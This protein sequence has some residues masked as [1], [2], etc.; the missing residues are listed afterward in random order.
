MSEK[1][2]NAKNTS[3]VKVA[4][5]KVGV[6][7]KNTT[8]KS[9]IKKIFVLDTNVILH[10]SSCIFKF[11]EHDICIPIQV[12]EELDNHKKGLDTINFHAR[13][14]NRIFDEILPR[15]C[16]DKWVSLGKGLGKIKVLLKRDFHEEVSKNL[17]MNK[18]DNQIIN[19]A[20]DL[21]ETMKI[22]DPKVKVVIVS[23][24]I[25]VRSKSKILNIFCEDYLNEK[26]SN[27]D[28]LFREVRTIKQK[29]DFSLKLFSDKEMEFKIEGALEN[30]NFI[31]K[32]AT[33]DVLVRYRDGKIKP[34]TKKSNSN[35]F[36]LNYLNVEQACAIDALLDPEIKLVALEGCPGTGKTLVSL[37]CAL[38]QLD[39]TE[40][41]RV[42]FA[43]ATV[44]MGN[45][46]IGFL[47]GDVQ[48]KISPYAKGVSDNV[49]FLSISS[50]KN[51]KKIE[52]FSKD[53]LF[54]IEALAHL[55]GRSL[56]NVLF[57][58]DEAQ[59]LT[60]LE[61]RTIITRAG[62]GTKIIIMA[63][64]RQIDNPYVDQ[65]SNGFTYAVNQF[66]AK[67]NPMFSYVHLNKSERSELA[68]LASEIL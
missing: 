6:S 45:R 32:F 13:E 57:I 22:K 39:K 51:K 61:I 18:Y 58:V 55:R 12:L 65:K 14:F 7:S 19:A 3:P 59:N 67:N 9:K 16:S 37:A 36:N 66:I 49:D 40:Y 27:I 33:T 60:P 34:I 15:N 38:G 54:V 4:L 21:Q 47:P 10:D 41:N 35:S 24:D 11:E 64:T 1:A 43:V 20:Y 23:K 2:R 68:R 62:E 46:D 48:D 63:D 50:A 29:D 30:E 52:T 26:V 53:G 44:P 28:F 5:K 31:L 17:D 8:L 42:L 56:P 25:N